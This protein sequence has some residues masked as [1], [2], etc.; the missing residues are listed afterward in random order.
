MKKY[1]LLFLV[2]ALCSHDMFLK[3]DDYF[4]NADSQATLQL[5]NGT[6]DKSDNVI[7]RDRMLDAS[8]VAHGRRIVID[9]SQ[10]YDKETTT[11]LDF[12]TG[13]PGTYVLGVSTAPRNIE[14]TADKFN[15]YLEHDG[16]V[17]MLL[18]RKRNNQLDQDVNEKY[19]KHVKTIFQVGDQ[20]TNDWKTEL[21]YPIE[22]VPL[23]NPYDLHAGHEM[24]VKLLLSG[25]PL[26]NQLVLI[27]H[28]VMDKTHT[29]DGST[30]SHEDAEQGHTHEGQLELRTDSNGILNFDITESGVW[31]LRTIHMTEVEDVELTH[32][33]N[34]ATLT[35]QIG[36]GHEHDDDS[37]S[38]DDA[39]SHEPEFPTTL[40]L[41]ISLLV[42][43]GLFLF[44]KFKK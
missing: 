24:R 23:E 13:D 37:H 14:M 35:F 28:E 33:S 41:I 42:V 39:H 26:A 18:S 25:E 3:F 1:F 4:L 34:W 27:G 22:F 10:W 43:L 44:F 8:M 5:F 36:D 19:S 7:D 40:F 38:H 29:H 9:S 6:F 32:E 16:V 17:D 20:L 31:H 30:H 15:D 21:G 2:I 12:K 11:F